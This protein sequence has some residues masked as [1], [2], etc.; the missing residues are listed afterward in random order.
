VVDVSSGVAHLPGN[1][2][3]EKIARFMEA[4]CGHSAIS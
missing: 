4:V 1:T 3:P 2:D